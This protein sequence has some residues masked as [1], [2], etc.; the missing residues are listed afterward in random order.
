MA[1]GVNWKEVWADVWGDVWSN[2]PPVEVPDVVGE[3]QAAG[4]ATL[5]G[6]GFTVIVATAYSS[7][8]PV[9]E[10]ISLQP[11]A[12]TLATAGSSVTITVS[13]GEA[14][15]QNAAGRSKK[16]RLYVEIDG[17]RFD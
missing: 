2:T 11:T 5:E 1:I 6:D 14:P 12:G 16:R 15:A 7:T 3:T 17:Q 4:T 10:I 13:L 8:A 9:G